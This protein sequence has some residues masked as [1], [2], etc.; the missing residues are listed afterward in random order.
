MKE[1]LVTIATKWGS[2]EIS[3][4]D[5]VK[6]LIKDVK[7]FTPNISNDELEETVW[8]IGDDNSWLDVSV[9]VLDKNLITNKQ[10][11]EFALIVN[12]LNKEK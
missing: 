4:K 11:D 1:T 3:K 2:G 12:Q 5:E 9:K 10:F 6:N 7:I 8:S